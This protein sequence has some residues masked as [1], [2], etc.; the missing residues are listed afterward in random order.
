M[1]SEHRGDLRLEFCDA[2]VEGQKAAGEL[3]DDVCGD[4]LAGQGYPLGLRRGQGSGGS[5]GIAGQQYRGTPCRRSSRTPS[6]EPGTR[7]SARLAAG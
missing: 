6:P 3:S 4:V 5:T 1:L 2:L 7:W